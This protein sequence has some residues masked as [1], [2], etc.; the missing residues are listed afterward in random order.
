MLCW[1]A[2]ASLGFEHKSLNLAKSPVMTGYLAEISEMIFIQHSLDFFRHRAIFAS[3]MAVYMLLPLLSK[4][5]Q[6]EL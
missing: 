6:Q 5:T 3:I 1:I 4:L 2:V